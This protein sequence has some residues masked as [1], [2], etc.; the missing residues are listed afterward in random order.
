MQ[1]KTERQLIKEVIN[2]LLRAP[3]AK[4]NRLGFT[5]IELLVVIAIIGILIAL[6][7]PAVQATRES[8]RRIQCVNNLKQMGIAFHNHHDVHGFFPTGGWG[9]NWVGDPDAGFD[10][11]QPGGWV[12][13]ILPY[14]E[15]PDIHALGAHMPD[16]QKMEMGKER[17][18][19]HIKQFYCP[20]RRQPQLLPTR[21]TMRNANYA[22]RVA[23][24]DYA[25]NCGSYRRNEISGG[26]P[27]GSTTPPSTPTQE[28]GI[29]YRTSEVTIA[30]VT[31]GTSQTICVG[32]K[33]L[34]V[35][36][37]QT[38]TDP[39]DNENMYC[40]Y[41]NDVFRS[42]N[43]SRYFP[44]RRDAKNIF[45]QVFGSMHIDSFNAVM[46]DGSVRP[47]SYF[48]DR[49]NYERLG[50]RQDGEAIAMENTK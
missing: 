32:E 48:V 33:Y 2:M 17:L 43:T 9:W 10:K 46:C 38:G 27:R 24:T 1:A 11:H 49:Q 12:Y 36:R 45:L 37:W 42:T 6:L 18:E 39:A 34:A 15:Q 41:D 40:G 7:L 8:A 30:N 50:N 4:N 3:R 13:N 28:N 23:K 14:I 29:S 20:T 47:I 31:D 22:P 26:P 16:A 44:P 25:V 5:L 35:K 21:Y 19:K